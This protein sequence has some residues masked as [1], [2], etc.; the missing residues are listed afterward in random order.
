MRNLVLE[1]DPIL[2]KRCRP[3]DFD[4]H[5]DDTKILTE[6]LFSAMV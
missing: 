6:D 4:Y 1:N 2:R 5:Q 3:F